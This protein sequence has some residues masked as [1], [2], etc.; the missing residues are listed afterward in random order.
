M[1][2]SYLDYSLC[3]TSFV[4]PD[5]GWRC[6]IYSSKTYF[7]AANKMDFFV[8]ILCMTTAY[9]SRRNLPKQI[10]AALIGGFMLFFAIIITWTLGYQLLYAGRIFPG[11]SVAGVDISGLSPNDAALKLSSNSLVSNYWKN[12]ISRRRP[13]LGCVSCGI[14]HGVRPICKRIG[15]L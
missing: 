12:I 15:S 6:P 2:V 8:I 5:S 11:V 13:G 7:N 10:L 9:I 3:L 4:Y 1:R 14:G